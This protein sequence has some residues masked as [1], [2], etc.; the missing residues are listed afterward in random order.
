[1]RIDVKAKSVI[2][3]AEEYRKYYG[4]LTTDSTKAQFIV[5]L[6]EKRDSDQSLAAGRLVQE[7]GEKFLNE[8]W[9]G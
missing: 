9:R 7:L 3:Q 8:R 1:M 2:E 4:K 5:F 6:K